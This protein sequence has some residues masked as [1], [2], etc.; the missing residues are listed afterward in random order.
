MALTS[1]VLCF[2]IFGGIRGIHSPPQQ[3][4]QDTSTAF[5]DLGSLEQVSTGTM[6]CLEQNQNW[7]G[8]DVTRNNPEAVKSLESWNQLP[9]TKSTKASGQPNLVF[10]MMIYQTIVFPKA[11]ETLLSEPDAKG[12][13]LIHSKLKANVPS[14]FQEYLMEEKVENDRC[15]NHNVVLR[16]MNLTMT[17]SPDFTHV[18]VVSGDTLPIKPLSHMYADLLAEGASRFCADAQYGRA[19]TYFIMGRDHVA[20]LD[21]NKD[22]LR[23]LI[24]K[25]SSE[26]STLV[27]PAC[28][29]EDMFYWPLQ[30]R[31]EKGYEKVV[32]SCPMLT[33]WSHTDKY[34]S[35]NVEKCNCPELLNSKKELGNCNHPSVFYDI[36][37]KAVQEIFASEGGHWYLR[38]FTGDAVK[39]PGDKVVG[40]T[41]NK[42]DGKEPL[43]NAAS[44]ELKRRMKSKGTQLFMIGG[45]IPTI[46]IAKNLKETLH[47]AFEE[48]RKK[49]S[50]KATKLFDE[51]L[52][53][54]K[55]F[56]S[57]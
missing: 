3:E 18:A 54:M 1:V 11:W 20:F 15:K 21:Q 37:A 53:L 44:M 52:T 31:A 43:D 17:K 10:L 8:P 39:M 51:A 50:T 35:F 9:A 32:G 2:S 16:M 13:M 41:V 56:P 12:G 6:N 40:D 29:D 33:D 49:G 48:Q 55:E 45:P 27:H 19:E 30:Q 46:D 36:S 5:V 14:F 28:T 22:S 47:S 25:A 38:K 26:F 7:M 24:D 42:V 34:W 57:S 23:L 4:E